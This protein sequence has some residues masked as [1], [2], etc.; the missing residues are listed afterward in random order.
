MLA[1]G[2]TL[3]PKRLLNAY[4]LGIFPWYDQAP[5]LWWSPDPRC[6][7]FLKDFHI[8][9]SLRKVLRAQN[10][11]VK[12]DQNFKEVIEGCAKPRP[13]EEEGTWINPSMQLAY[14]ALHD[15][16]YAHSVEVYKETRLIGGLYGVAYGRNF[17]AESMFSQEKN[18]SKIALAYLVDYLSRLQFEW[19]DCQFYTSHLGSLGAKV[20]PRSE[21]LQKLQD[22][23][24][25]E[26]KI[27]KWKLSEKPK[28]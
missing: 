3:S 24:K 6:V 16:G 27:G 12:L 21:F 15:L 11:V 10:F 2:G 5:I 17:F 25:F 4:Q 7:L 8:S 9:K 13:K 18:A 14:C 1:V 20:I 28:I 26:S 23:N 22:N 19:I